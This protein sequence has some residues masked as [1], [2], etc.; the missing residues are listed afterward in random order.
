MPSFFIEFAFTRTLC[1]PFF[2]ISNQSKFTQSKSNQSDVSVF[3]GCLHLIHI[4]IVSTNLCLSNDSIYIHTYSF[5]DSIHTYMEIFN[6]GDELEISS[7]DS[8]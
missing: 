5:I 1:Q 2:K 8:F 4:W 6:Q 3:I 7:S